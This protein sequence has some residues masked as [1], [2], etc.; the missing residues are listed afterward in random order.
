[1]LTTPDTFGLKPPAANTVHAHTPSQEGPPW[2]HSPTET[3]LGG[4]PK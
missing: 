2:W 1:M 3:F 4:P